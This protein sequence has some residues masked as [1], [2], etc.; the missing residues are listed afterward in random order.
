MRF[1]YSIA[2]HG[3]HNDYI[4]YP[5]VWEHQEKVFWLLDETAP[6]VE[7]TTATTIMALNVAYIPEFVKWKVQQGFKKINSWPHGAGG[8]NNH[9]AYWPPQLNVKVLPPNIKQEITDKYNNEFYPWM[10][11]NW[12]LFTGVK[13]SGID[14]ETF[15]NHPYGIKSCLLYTSDAADE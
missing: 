7:V 2:A 5:S 8:I 9:F 1:H 14:K 15:V 6:Q 4:R 10:E 13:E 12:Q 11:D 3:E